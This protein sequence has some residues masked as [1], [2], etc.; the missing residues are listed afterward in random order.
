M[1]SP[2]RAEV[3]KNNKL[4]SSAYALASYEFNLNDDTEAFTRRMLSR[5][6]LL[7]II[8]ITILGDACLCNSFIHPFARSKES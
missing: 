8:A 6:D 3:S 1:F 5:S 2:V 4:S 7:P